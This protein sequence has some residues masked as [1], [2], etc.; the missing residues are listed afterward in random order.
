MK[1]NNAKAKK[2]NELVDVM[3]VPKKSITFRG[4]V[5][6][7]GDLRKLASPKDGEIVLVEYAR[8]RNAVTNRLYDVESN[9]CYIHVG[10][11]KRLDGKTAKA[12]A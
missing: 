10:G 4:V 6:Y 9:E 1:K 12:V 11:W 7:K 5:R 3:D 8:K 2:A